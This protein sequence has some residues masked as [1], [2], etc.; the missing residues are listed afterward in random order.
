MN[1]SRYDY[2]IFI[3]AIIIIKILTIAVSLGGGIPA[4]TWLSPCGRVPPPD[5]SGFRRRG[6]GPFSSL[7]RDGLSYLAS[8]GPPLTFPS[9]LGL[10]VFEV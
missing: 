9:L 8:L 7:Q 4:S 1:G 6:G 10:C 3:V 2:T 5:V